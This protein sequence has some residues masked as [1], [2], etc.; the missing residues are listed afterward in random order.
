M[1]RAVMSGS[2]HAQRAA[3][4]KEDFCLSTASCFDLVARDGDQESIAYGQL[5][6]L[7]AE[8]NLAILDASH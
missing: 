2:W 8:A 4:L 7:L 5:P 1:V 3:V 6:E